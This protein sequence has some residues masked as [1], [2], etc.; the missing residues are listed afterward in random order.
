M[1]CL[2]SKFISLSIQIAALLLAAGFSTGALA[3]TWKV[4]CTKNGKVQPTIN[5]AASGD[6][7]EIN[8]IC[9]EN[10]VI[11]DK[12][13]TMIGAASGGPHG[14]TGVAAD[15]DAVLIEDSRSTHLED[16]TISNP[17]FTGVRI[18]VNSEV[19]MTDCNVSDAGSGIQGRSTGIWV[20]GSSNFT[21]TRLTLNNNRNG[22]AAL[23]SRAFCRECDFNGNTRFA[24]FATQNALVSLLDSEVDGALG[25]AADFQSYIDIDC[26]S[27]VSAHPCSLDAT[28][29][30][31][32][33]AYGSSVVFYDAGPFS[34]SIEAYGGSQAQVLGAQ[35]QS[36]PGGNGIDGGSMLHVEPFSDSSRLMGTTHVSGFS[37]ALFRDGTTV[38]DG[39]I[40]CD[41]G[42]DAWADPAI[43]LGSVVISGCDHAPDP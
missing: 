5:S 4:D 16:L 14:I 19:T 37:H 17:L 33:A 40:N 1:S 22:L 27:H 36:N 38:L 8:G 18:V 25:I 35:Q 11:R 32:V 30:A 34:G 39:S 23:Q 6:V 2:S 9:S 26:L 13:L 24:G 20:Q 42:G 7:V 3:K 21:G 10:I 31:G 43:G 29:T 15:T 28:G 41:S 12:G